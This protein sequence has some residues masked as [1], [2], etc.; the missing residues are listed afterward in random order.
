MPRPM[1]ATGSRRRFPEPPERIPEDR[2][3]NGQIAGFALAIC[4]RP[5]GTCVSPASPVD[6]VVERS[7]VGVLDRLQR[8]IG[9]VAQRHQVHAEVTLGEAEHTLG[10]LLIQARR[11]PGANAEV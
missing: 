11:V 2:S 10:L 3:L 8:T 7:T 6:D 4:T 5:K 9:G 1:Q